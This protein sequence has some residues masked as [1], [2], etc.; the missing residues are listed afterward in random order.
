M[1]L[2]LHLVSADARRFA[3]P[4]ALWIAVTIGG[5]IMDGFGPAMTAQQDG[6]QMFVMSMLIGWVAATGLGVTLVALVMQQHP[7]VG[8]NAWWMTRPVTPRLLLASRFLLLG[9]V[10]LGV[11]AVCD[12]ILMTVHGVSAGQ[13]LRVLI[14]WAIVGLVAL[15]VVMVAA[16]LTT[17]LGRF[18]LLIGASLIVVGL[19]LNIA[20]AIA[21]SDSHPFQRWGMTAYAGALISK[22]DDPTALVIAW[23]VLIVVSLWLLHT[24]YTRRGRGRAVTIG[25]AGGVIAV[26]VAVAWPWPLL[27]AGP[28]A[29][30]WAAASGPLRLEGP[31]QHLYFDNAGLQADSRPR[32][33]T[34]YARVYVTGVPEGWIATARLRRGTLEFPSTSMTSG[35]FK[36]VATLTSS[37]PATKAADRALRQLLGVAD[38]VGSDI[39]GDTTMPIVSTLAANVPAGP[40]EATYYGEFDIT[41][42]QFHEAAVVPLRVGA[43]F[44]DGSHSLVIDDL[45]SLDRGPALRVRTS[46]ATAALDRRSPPTYSYYLRNRQA[47]EALG[48][49]L[50]HWSDLPVPGQFMVGRYGFLGSPF[51]FSLGSG[52]LRFP[53]TVAALFQSSRATGGNHRWDDD[54]WLQGAELVI[55]KTI[56]AGTVVRRLELTGLTVNP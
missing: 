25:L 5:S 32:W 15:G 29:P 2:I 22:P 14:E 53:T 17:S 42:F 12:A 44:Q 10:V 39:S 16:A 35:P 50:Q 54:K 51:G 21:L 9:P 34:A 19:A 1:K 41:L 56:D 38:I 36:F 46:R 43:S 7:A 11:P 30:T 6:R 23:V 52:Y 4:I 37:G 40:V 8:S 18:A 48:G 31:Q 20:M 47:G 27:H 26:S 55:V 33:R 3:I 49:K 13:M 28:A 45:Q 24:L